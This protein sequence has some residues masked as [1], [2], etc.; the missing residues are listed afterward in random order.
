MNRCYALTATQAI[1]IHLLHNPLSTITTAKGDSLTFEAQLQC[2]NQCSIYLLLDG[3]I[4]LQIIFKVFR[5]PVWPINISTYNQLCTYDVKV[6][7]QE[8]VWSA[9]CI[10]KCIFER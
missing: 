5:S 3:N 2:V 10:Y 1:S 7:K 4:H 9:F 6:I 8:T